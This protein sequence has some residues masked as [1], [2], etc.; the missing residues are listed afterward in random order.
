MLGVLL[1]VLGVWCVGCVCGRSA[2]V[3]MLGVLMCVWSIRSAAV[4]MLGVLLDLLGVL[5][6]L[7]WEYC[8]VCDGSVYD[9]L[10]WEN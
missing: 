2:A 1:S 6:C 10:C 9:C 4:S 3:S 8:C 5:Q 7:C